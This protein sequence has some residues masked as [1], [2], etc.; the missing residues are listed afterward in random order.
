MSAPSNSGKPRR[1]EYTAPSRKNARAAQKPMRDIGVEQFRRPVGTLLG[2]GHVRPGSAFDTL[3]RKKGR[4][5]FEVARDEVDGKTGA[6]DEADLDSRAY[7]DID[8]DDPADAPDARG[9]TPGQVP[10][11]TDL[12]ESLWGKQDS[13]DEATKPQESNQQESTNKILQNLRPNVVRTAPASRNLKANAGAW[14]A[15]K[16]KEPEKDVVDTAARP[17]AAHLTA[18]NRAMIRRRLLA[19][20]NKP[21]AEESFRKEY[22]ERTKKLV[23]Q[24]PKRQAPVDNPSTSR[25]QPPQKSQRK[26]RASPAAPVFSSEEEDEV[27]DEDED[28]DVPIATNN[29]RRHVTTAPRP[30]IHNRQNQKATSALPDKAVVDQ[31]LQE[32]GDD[33]DD[34]GDL[35]T[36]QTNRRRRTQPAPPSQINSSPDLPTTSS[37]SSNSKAAA[38]PL[39]Q[40]IQDVSSPLSDKALVDQHLQ[41]DN[42][43]D[44]DD[45]DDDD[46]P[47]I[48]QTNRRRRAKPAP[49]PQTNN[50]FDQ[51]DNSL[52]N[53]PKAA[54][55]PV[56]Q[57]ATEQFSP[58]S[59]RATFDRLLQLGAQPPRSRTPDLSHIPMARFPPTASMVRPSTASFTPGF[60]AINAPRPQS[61]L[62]PQ[63]PTPKKGTAHPPQPKRARAT[64]PPPV[65][66]VKATIAKKDATPSPPRKKSRAAPKG[67]PAAKPAAKPA[68]KTAAKTIKTTAAPIKKKGAAAVASK[69]GMATKV[70]K[71]KSKPGYDKV[72]VTDES[73]SAH[74]SDW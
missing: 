41:D 36:V 65:T 50:S 13:S 34:G 60:K 38:G 32:E 6:G 37:L 49:P 72:S 63:T 46:D 71:K 56:L 21:T 9:D 58:L 5:R 43:D 55:D 17:T 62:Q 61:Q 35:P 42:E 27:D 20:K 69:K 64:V 7:R 14:G 51:P 67:K 10:T 44:D 19:V 24:T 25:R 11:P 31:V 59:T 52:Q 29:R 57:F 4:D 18:A 33:D 68:P 48:T 45:D 3:A 1:T 39:L 16:L 40:T 54:P 30:Q 74:D 2:A 23:I 73:G 66:T 53:N 28:D 8:T 47:P 22:F 12:D 70:V 26:R 15:S